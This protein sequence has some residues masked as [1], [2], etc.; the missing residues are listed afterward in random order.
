MNEGQ[1]RPALIQMLDV[2]ARCSTPR[3]VLDAGASCS[4][5]R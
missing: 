2:R 4:T 3:Q 1:P 5:P